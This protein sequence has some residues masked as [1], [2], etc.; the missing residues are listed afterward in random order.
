[1][2][3]QHPLPPTSDVLR[4]R[5]LCNKASSWGRLI[6]QNG[7]CAISCN[8]TK[9]FCAI[10]CY[11]TKR[12]LCNNASHKLTLPFVWYYT[13]LK[14]CCPVQEVSQI[15]LKSILHFLYCN[16]VL[17]NLKDCLSWISCVCQTCLSIIEWFN[18]RK[19]FI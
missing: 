2:H 6:G 8:C 10:R 1:M 17:S 12:V 19:G 14:K 18:Q 13:S 9:Q 11:C 5:V 15:A 4:Q 3:F 7:F 16:I